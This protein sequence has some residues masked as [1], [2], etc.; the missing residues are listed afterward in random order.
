MNKLKISIILDYVFYY[1]CIFLSLT[2]WLRF[3]LH[4]TALIISISSLCSLI[5][6]T[7]IFLLKRKKSQKDNLSQLDKV[8]ANNFMNEMLF[9]SITE[10]CNKIC[11]ILN[12]S[13]ENIENDY[14]FYNNCIIKPLFTLQ[15]IT[16]NNILQLLI[17][18]KSINYEKLIII[19]NNFDNNCPAFNNIFNNVKISFFNQYEFY[20]S[21]LKKINYKP[22]F[23]TKKVA[24]KTNYKQLFNLIFSQKKAKS[25]FMYAFLLFF[26]GLF[27]R[28]NIYYIISSSIMFILAIIAKFNKKSSQIKNKVF[29]I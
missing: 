27:F 15:K 1:F 29:E 9:L 28:Y 20:N 5:F 17:Q 10:Q 4:N 14:I 3:F 25:Y 26:C 16:S 21:C 18:T 19:S 22:N 11:T 23:E 2:I 13:T 6:I 8:N 12:I 24:K 7:L